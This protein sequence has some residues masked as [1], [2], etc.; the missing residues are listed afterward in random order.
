MKVWNCGRYEEMEIGQKVFVGRSSSGRSVFGE[1]AI[2]TGVTKQHLVFTTVS[3]SIIKT[4][5]DN[6]HAVAGKANKAGYFVSTALRAE[7]EYFK[8]RVAYW[9]SKKLCFDYK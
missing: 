4:A 8:E 5:I 7:G 6:L 2:L 9:N 3:G 1:E